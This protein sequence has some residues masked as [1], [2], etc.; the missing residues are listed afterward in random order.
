MKKGR[1]DVRKQTRLAECMV[2]VDTVPAF[3]SF[4]RYDVID[5]DHARDTPRRQEIVMDPLT[6]SKTGSRAHS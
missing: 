4:V 5:E 3:T 6:R 2:A 1:E